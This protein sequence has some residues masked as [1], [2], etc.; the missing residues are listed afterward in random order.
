[1]HSIFILN[2]YGGKC[3]FLLNR[4]YTKE[5]SLTEFFMRVVMMNAFVIQ[6]INFSDYCLS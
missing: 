2:I 5:K 6:G 1:M 3:G 4:D